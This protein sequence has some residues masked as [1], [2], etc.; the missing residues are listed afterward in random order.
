M[1]PRL[2]LALALL[3][4]ACPAQAIEQNCRF[5]AVKV[6]REACYRQQEAELAAKRKAQKTAEDRTLETMQQ[7]RRDDADVYRSLRSICR[8]C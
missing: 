4:S 6:E 8:G 2:P 7:M 3:A 1:T 5:I